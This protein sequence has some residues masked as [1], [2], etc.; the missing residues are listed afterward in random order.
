MIIYL[1]LADP[2][3]EEA[4]NN[5]FLSGY[6]PR[7][8]YH[9]GFDG[10]PVEVYMVNHTD[11]LSISLRYRYNLSLSKPILLVENNR[12]EFDSYVG[13]EL[14]NVNID[15]LVAQISNNIT[16]IPTPTT[17][18]QTTVSSS[19]NSKSL[20]LISGAVIALLYLRKSRN[21]EKKVA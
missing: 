15:E 12:S 18:V 8:R 5:L 6:E 17:D 7:L 11:D 19:S 10:L 13:S 1:L 2:S 20:I 3:K 4:Y 21:K 9:S 16:Y 14:A